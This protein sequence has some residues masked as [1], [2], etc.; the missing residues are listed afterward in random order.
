MK[1]DE[2]VAVLDR[3]THPHMLFTL[4][5]AGPFDSLAPDYGHVKLRIA[6]KTVDSATMEPIII[7]RTRQMT[8]LHADEQAFVDEV[9]R[10]VKNAMIHEAG[11]F[12]RYKGTAIHHPHGSNL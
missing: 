6:H 9:W 7:N 10:C 5:K 2:A 4:E 1:Y 12:F 8:I 11:E 3:I